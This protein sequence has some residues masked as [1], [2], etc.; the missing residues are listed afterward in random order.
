MMHL[1]KHLVSRFPVGWQLALRRALY[2]CELRLK[3]FSHDEPEFG[4]LHEWV[5]EGD[6][7][8]DIGANVGRYTAALSRLVGATGHVFAFEP[9]SET[10]HL[11][12]FNARLF[13]FPNVTLFNTAVSD[14]FGFLGMEIPTTESGLP[15]IYQARLTETAMDEKVFCLPLDALS[16]P[17]KVSLIKIDV[18]GHEFRALKGMSELLKKDMPVLIV[19]GRSA[20]VRSFLLGLGY[21]D[22]LMEGS[23]NTIYSAKRSA[24]TQAGPTIAVVRTRPVSS[25]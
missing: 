7:V 23:P 16:M 11:L 19:E 25:P 24:R 4:K 13:R 15:D 2:T 9:V 10:F 18:E 22:Y 12:A 20:E 1:L 3:T 14:T 5:V 8:L 21:D 17:G 6:C